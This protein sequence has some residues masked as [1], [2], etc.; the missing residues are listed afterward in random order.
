[1]IWDCGNILCAQI[2]AGIRN[3]TMEYV[4]GVR[5]ILELAGHLCAHLGDGIRWITCK[6]M[7]PTFAFQLP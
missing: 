1:M 2:C 3:V 4:G 6:I 5:V 7:Y